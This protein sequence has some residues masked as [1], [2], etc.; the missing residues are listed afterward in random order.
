MKKNCAKTCGVCKPPCKDIQTEEN[1]KKWADYH[2]NG[3]QWGD[4]MKKNCAKT[5][6]A[7]S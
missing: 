6:G 3:E 1:C 4:W 2:C 5:C 7:C